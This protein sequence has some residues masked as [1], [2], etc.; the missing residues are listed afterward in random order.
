[1]KE[2]IGKCIRI[3]KFLEIKTG[4]ISWNSNK[5]ESEQVVVTAD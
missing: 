3:P 5:Q 4:L 2:K 1:M